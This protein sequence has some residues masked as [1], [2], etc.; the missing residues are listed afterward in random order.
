MKPLEFEDDEL[1]ENLY[2]DVDDFEAT[3]LIQFAYQIATGMV[4]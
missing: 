3:D 1:N 4:S 2:P